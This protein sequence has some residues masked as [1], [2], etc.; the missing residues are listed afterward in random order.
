M[1]KEA[2]LPSSL[3]FRAIPFFAIAIGSCLSAGVAAAQNMPIAASKTCY[4]SKFKFDNQ[5]AYKLD[6][7]T[8]SNHEFRGLL[9]QG[10][11]RT[12]SLDKANVK[13]GDEVF[14][15]YRLDQG[16]N[17]TQR[18]CEKDGTT[19]RYHPDGNTWN[20]WSKG[21]ATNNNRCRFRN[22]KCITSVD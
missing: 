7:F 1:S 21:T 18:T 3:K 20:Y 19:L 12:W 14:L 5:G 2:V 22:N 17:N 13:A 6:L 16:S 11:S 4:V 10:Q 8:A 15:T 9:T